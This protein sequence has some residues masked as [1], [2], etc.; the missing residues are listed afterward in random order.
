MDEAFPS[1]RLVA[2]KYSWKTCLVFLIVLQR[3][4]RRYLEFKP[5]SF[6]EVT[7]LCIKTQIK[8]T[9]VFHI[10]TD[11]GWDK[12]QSLHANLHGTVF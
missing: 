5:N 7:S 4:Y 3:I 9:E 2:E 11:L 12:V 1:V 8:L 6:M 10:C